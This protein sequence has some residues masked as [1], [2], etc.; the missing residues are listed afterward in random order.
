MEKFMEGNLPKQGA[1]RTEQRESDNDGE[2]PL[3]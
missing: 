2:K 3:F 1:P